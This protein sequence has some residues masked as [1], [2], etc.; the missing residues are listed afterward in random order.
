MCYFKRLNDAKTKFYLCLSENTKDLQLAINN[1][2]WEHKYFL[3]YLLTKKKIFGTNSW[4]R[5]DKLQYL[6]LD[7]RTFNS[8]KSYKIPCSQNHNHIPLIRIR[9][10]ALEGNWD[11]NPRASVMV[12]PDYDPSPQRTLPIRSSLTTSRWGASRTWPESWGM[13]TWFQDWDR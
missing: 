11:R 5:Y 3:N 2:W 4:I 8:S 6:D 13:G 7:F 1:S 9:S 12:S 10:Q